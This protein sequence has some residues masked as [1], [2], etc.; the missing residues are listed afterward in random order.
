MSVAD[1][2]GFVLNL[3]F[4]D[5]D[6]GDDEEDEEADDD[7]DEENWKF[8]LKILVDLVYMEKSVF[9]YYIKFEENSVGKCQ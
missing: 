8:S 7:E 5:E 2:K 1:D 4:S 9:H 6:E 3:N